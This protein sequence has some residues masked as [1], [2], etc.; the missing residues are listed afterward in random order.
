MCLQKIN[1]YQQDRQ[2]SGH[3]TRL[4]VPTITVIKGKNN[5]N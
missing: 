1:L 2:E 5:E 4:L 3:T